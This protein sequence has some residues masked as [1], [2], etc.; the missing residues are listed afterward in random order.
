MRTV[1]HNL[2]YADGTVIPAGVSVR[3]VERFSVNGGREFRLRIE[4]NGRLWQCKED[5]LL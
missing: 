4:F 5:D 2:L 1:R 3:F